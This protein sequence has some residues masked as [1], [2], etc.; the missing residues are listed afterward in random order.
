MY[1][2]QIWPAAAQDIREAAIWYNQRQRGLGKRFTAEVRTKV[3]Q[4]KKNPLS[5]SV[6]YDD[7]RTAVL[8]IFPFMIHYT[9][10]NHYKQ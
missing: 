6:R 3:D 5:W 7:T 4:L 10:V 9:T 8:E 1:Q 2:V